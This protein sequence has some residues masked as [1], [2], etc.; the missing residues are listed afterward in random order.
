MEIEG[1]G[2]EYKDQKIFEIEISDDS[3][4]YDLILDV[5]HSIEYSFENIYVNVHT[6]FPSGE[7]TT[8]KVSLQLTD[9]LDQWQGKCN[10]SACNV[11]ILLQERVYFKELGKYTIAFEQFNRRNP[12]IGIQSLTLKLLKLE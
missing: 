6:T 12:L 11:S 5:N 10:N 2:W 9:D 8:D 7:K 1:E 4:Y 3:T